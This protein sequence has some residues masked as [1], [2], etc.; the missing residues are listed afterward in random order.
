VYLT[1]HASCVFVGSPVNLHRFMLLPAIRSVLFKMDYVDPKW[2]SI[3]F[4]IS[5]D[6]MQSGMYG[7]TSVPTVSFLVNDTPRCGLV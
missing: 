1:L 6:F 2:T 4:N 3:R 7:T 5:V